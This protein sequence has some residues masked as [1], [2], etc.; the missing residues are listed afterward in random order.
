MSSASVTITPEE[1]VSLIE[2]TGTLAT[3]A[4]DAYS[5]AKALA[6]KAGISSADLDGFDARFMKDYTADPPSAK[7]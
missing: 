1:V 7:P 5:A 3:H 4:I 6:A 2:I